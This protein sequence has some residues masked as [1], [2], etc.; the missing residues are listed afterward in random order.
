MKLLTFPSMVSVLLRA[1]VSATLFWTVAADR[2]EGKLGGV[3]CD[4]AGDASENALEG[5]T[6]AVGCICCFGV[7]FLIQAML[8]KRRRRASM[9]QSTKPD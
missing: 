4:P 5:F 8:R 1:A 6:E 7:S 2:T 3:V 9:A